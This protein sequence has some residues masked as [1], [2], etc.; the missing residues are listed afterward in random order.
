MIF[1]ACPACFAAGQTAKHKAET[2]ESA[3]VICKQLGK[4]LQSSLEGAVI[5]MHNRKAMTLVC[6]FE[7]HESPDWY[8]LSSDWSTIHDLILGQGLILIPRV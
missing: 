4:C 7:Q 8:G 6:P 2:A 5:R 3:D 1:P